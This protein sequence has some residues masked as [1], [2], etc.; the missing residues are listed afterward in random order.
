M[1]FS[2]IHGHE[3]IKQQL[4]SLVDSGRIPHA[5]LLQGKQGVGKFALARAMA[6]YIHCENRS[7]GDSC[8][9]CP[10]CI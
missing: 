2:D 1:R 3:T 9:V 10:S 4:A 6:Q 7:G 8:G 5:L